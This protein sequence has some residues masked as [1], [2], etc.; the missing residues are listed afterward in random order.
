MPGDPNLFEDKLREVELTHFKL[1]EAEIPEPLKTATNN[2][3]M[4]TLQEENTEATT[5]RTG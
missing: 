3:A 2:S 5:G 1:P 4:R